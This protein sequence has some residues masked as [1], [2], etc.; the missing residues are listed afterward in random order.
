MQPTDRQ[1]TFIFKEAGCSAHG[2]GEAHR[3]CKRA[4]VLRQALEF[5]MIFKELPILTR[6]KPSV[7]GVEK[8]PIQSLAEIHQEIKEK[9][10]AAQ[11]PE[12]KEKLVRVAEIA[13]FKADLMDELQQV[14]NERFKNKFGNEKTNSD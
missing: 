11:T 9:K 7:K 13:E 12:E 3:G 5:Y 8:Q 14:L 6:A 2:E 1:Y 10:A 4:E